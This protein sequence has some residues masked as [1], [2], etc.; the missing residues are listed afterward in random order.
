MIAE[1]NSVATDEVMDVIRRGEFIEKIGDY[2][3]ISD[4]NSPFLAMSHWQ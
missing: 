3:N 4:K 2:S 1:V